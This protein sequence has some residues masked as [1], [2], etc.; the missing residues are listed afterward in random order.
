MP[1]FR[2]NGIDLYYERHG[3]GAPLL[4]IAG[5]GANVCETPYLTE[6]YARH[7]DYIIYDQR[8]CG[9]SDK[10]AGEYS[11]AAW[12][13]DADALL[14]ALGIESAAVYGSSM[15]GMVAQELALRH[16]ARVTALILGCTTG[17][18]IRGVRPAPETVQRMVANHEL[19]GDEALVVGWSLGYSA[20][21]IDANYDRLL[22]I[23][24]GASAY[25]APPDS[26]IRQVLAAARHDTW[27]R[28][29]AIACP[30]MILHGSEDVMI[31]AGNAHMLA[32]RI[33][34][35]DLRILE[36]MGHGYNLEAQHDADALVIDFV[37]RH[38]PATEPSR[39]VR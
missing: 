35:A 38:A 25:G 29:H 3:S 27:E 6:S 18:A 9:R 2:V 13:D 22:A 1:T 33:P 28:L 39:A 23:S 19:T 31:P 24:R 37:R 32:E 34:H 4:F 16:P 17:G 8:G 10:P 11:M 15:G 26:Y 30:T 20:A 21:F 5:L 12:A 7:F 36:G 14:D